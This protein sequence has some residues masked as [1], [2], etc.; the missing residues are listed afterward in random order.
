MRS[1]LDKSPGRGGSGIVIVQA[2]PS[3]PGVGGCSAIRHGLPSERKGLGILK[4]VLYT[5]HPGKSARTYRHG[6]LPF[7]IFPIRTTS[8]SRYP[9]SNPIAMP[10]SRSWATTVPTI[11]TGHFPL[12][13][14]ALGH[15]ERPCALSF[16]QG[17]S[18]TALRRRIRRR[19]SGICSLAFDS[20]NPLLKAYRRRPRGGSK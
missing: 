8:T 4:S 5:A 11:S 19:I 6:A 3:P 1:S 12:A 17:L 7:N 16:G 15:E 14:V 2:H 13:R 9:P 18:N 20:S 10:S